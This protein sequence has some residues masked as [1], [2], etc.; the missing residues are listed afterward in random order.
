MIIRDIILWTLYEKNTNFFVK[1]LNFAK[2]NN[3][4][5]KTMS[6]QSVM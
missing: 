4:E 6:S 3:K 5:T 1:D 2:K